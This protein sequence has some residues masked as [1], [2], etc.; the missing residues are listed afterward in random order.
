[1]QNFIFS[2]MHM[3]VSKATD[4][5]HSIHSMKE[6]KCVQSHQTNELGPW[7]H[8]PALSCPPQTSGR[9]LE[10]SGPESESSSPPKDSAE[11]NGTVM[12]VSLLQEKKNNP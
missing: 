9:C 4:P 7:S 5:N 6:M 3:L 2:K 10:D 8:S 11:T 1:M 12:S